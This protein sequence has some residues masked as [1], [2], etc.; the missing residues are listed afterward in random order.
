VNFVVFVFLL[1]FFRCFF[2]RCETTYLVYFVTILL[3]VNDKETSQW[4]KKP[5]W[6]WTCG[7]CALL[8][9]RS[10][11]PQGQSGNF[12]RIVF[13]YLM[14]VSFLLSPSLCLVFFFFFF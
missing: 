1:F 3:L 7:E 12:C 14:L 6:P 10:L 4:W 8:E 11:R 13:L 9:L 2:G 5:R